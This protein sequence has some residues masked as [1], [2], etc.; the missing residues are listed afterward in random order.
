MESP[1]ATAELRKA[2]LA[3]A[4]DPVVNTLS[5]EGAPQN[6]INYAGLFTVKGLLTLKDKTPIAGLPVALEIKRPNESVWSKVTEL[7]TG[8]DGTVSTP[9]TLGGNA[10]LRLTTV[11]T[12]EQA[13]SISQEAAMIVKSSIQLDRPVS[14]S[15]GAPIV[16]KA[17]LLPRVAGKSAQLQKNINGKW[18]NVGTPVLSDANGLFT[19][20]TA[21]P[22]RG[23]ITMRVQL[24]GDI[25]SEQFAIV[26]R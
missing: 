19:F 23:V 3:I 20:T 10:A 7:V 14:V 13:E 8:V 1:A 17:Q 9:M 4:P 26:V 15:R 12:W 16:V 18:Q 25:A 24:I 2:A 11:G 5:I 22:K 21:E 6:T